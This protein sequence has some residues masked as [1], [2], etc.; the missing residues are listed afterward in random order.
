MPKIQLTFSKG[1]A[2]PDKKRGFVARERG[3]TFETTETNDSEQSRVPNVQLLI[4]MV[5]LQESFQKA[6]RDKRGFDHVLLNSDDEFSLSHSASEESDT[7]SAPVVADLV[8]SESARPLFNVFASEI[9]DT[10][11]H[12]DIPHSE[13]EPR[14]RWS[15]A[16]PAGPAIWQNKGVEFQFCFEVD[17][18]LHPSL[19]ESQAPPPG[20]VE[21]AL[22]GQLR[23][24]ELESSQVSAADLERELES[25][26]SRVDVDKQNR[27]MRTRSKKRAHKRAKF[28]A[29]LMAQLVKQSRR[30]WAYNRPMTSLNESLPQVSLVPAF[31]PVAI[32]ELRKKRK[33]RRTG[34]KK[35]VQKKGGLAHL[36]NYQQ[37][38]QDLARGARAPRERLPV[39]AEMAK[40]VD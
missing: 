10:R 2:K 17:D 20:S 7:E 19:L 14:S 5:E 26:M 30:F 39:F 29:K 31:F 11:A 32:P 40:R 34:P 38:L 24:W 25:Y 35:N 36:R 23:L 8:A 28:D 27:A 18:S 13:T 3:K 6:N 33:F 21:A 16:S 9:F 12:R 4:K 22:E 1:P 37:K 15:E